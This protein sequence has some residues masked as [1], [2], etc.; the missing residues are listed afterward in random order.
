MKNILYIS[1]A[2]Q[3]GGAERSLLLLLA[4]LDRGRFQPRVVVRGRGPLADR[5][6]EMGVP[7]YTVPMI[8]FTRTANAVTLVRYFASWRKSARKIRRLLDRLQAHLVHANST[9]AFLYAMHLLARQRVPRIWHVRDFGLTKMSTVDRAVPRC[10]SAIILVSNAVGQ[11]VPRVRGVS[12]KTSVV[13]NGVDVDTFGPGDRAALR[14]E[15]GLG[16]S[17]P[18]AGIVGQV[19]PWK[20][21]DRFLAAAAKVASRLPDARFLVVGD[22]RFGDHPKLLDKLRAQAADLGLGGAV[23]FTGWRDDPAAVMNALD[24]LVVASENEPFG[25]VVI[26]AMACETP[27][28]A[29]RCGGPAEIIEHDRTGLLVEPF[30]VDAMADAMT[31]LLADPDRAAALGRAARQAVC[32]KFSADRYVQSIQNLYDRLLQ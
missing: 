14:G 5:L 10:A 2:S 25:R 9:T 8:R 28:V 11:V 27:V 31:A 7:W 23:I 19:V 26:E 3:L 30:D 18:V 21:H 15:L 12:D 6:D 22:D 32:E 1:H 13:Y 20:G 17:T 4:R 29:F 16:Q 24:V